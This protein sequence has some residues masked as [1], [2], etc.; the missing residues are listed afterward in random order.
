MALGRAWSVPPDLCGTQLVVLS[1]FL[2]VQAPS[3]WTGSGLR[4]ILG[5]LLPGALGD[6]WVLFFVFVFVFVFVLFCF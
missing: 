4:L 1:S 5:S 3:S 6:R 2:P